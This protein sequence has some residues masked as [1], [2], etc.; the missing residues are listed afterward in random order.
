MAVREALRNPSVSY[1]ALALPDKA[2]L[3]HSIRTDDPAGIEVY[4][5]NRFKDKRA[6]GEWF[7]LLSS[8]VLAFKTRKFQ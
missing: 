2:T 5:H 4:W 7:K 3:A 8:D 1:G 6:N